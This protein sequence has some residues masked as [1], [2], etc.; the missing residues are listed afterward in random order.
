MWYAFRHTGLQQFLYQFRVGES[1]WRLLKPAQYTYFMKYIG[2]EKLGEKQNKTKQ[3]HSFPKKLA[4]LN[5][6]NSKGLWNLLLRALSSAFWVYTGVKWKVDLCVCVCVKLQIYFLHAAKV[7]YIWLFS[8]FLFNRN[9]CVWEHSIFPI[10]GTVLWCQIFLLIPASSHTQ[11]P[12]TSPNHSCW[13]WGWEVGSFETMT[14]TGLR[15]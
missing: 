4:A 11:E 3:I 2:G 9:V 6:E 14:E 12:D 13:T 15:D 7:K 1:P 8:F 10:N 5:S